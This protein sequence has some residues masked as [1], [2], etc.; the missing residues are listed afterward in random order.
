MSE[1]YLSGEYIEKNPTLHVEDSAWKTKHIVQMLQKHHL[2][3]MTLCE[4]GCGAGEIL[5]LLQLQ[6]PPETQLYGYEISRQAYE[7]CKTREN[8]RLHFFCED[9][10][11]H[12]IDI[13]YDL[14]LC[15][16]V[17]EH[18][19][20]YM[21]FVRQLRSKGTYKL[22]HIPLEISVQTVLRASPILKGR[23]QYGH[24]HYFTRDTALAT[25]QDTGYEIVD[26]FYTPVNL[27]L[28]K[29][30]K[31]KLAKLPRRLFSR[32]NFD[33]TTRILGGYSLMV[34]TK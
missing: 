24:L 7:L 14:V 30:V 5:R 25:L 17:I 4:I 13:P 19:E 12:T 1:L 32:L 21:G 28:A 11:V 27:D 22:F 29:T 15:M 26:W 20:D 6:L 10:L 23:H 31:A 33:L 34:L 18:V 2:S 3:P 8:D 9:L 16:D